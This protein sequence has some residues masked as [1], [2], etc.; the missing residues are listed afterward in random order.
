MFGHDA[1]N[2][3]LADFEPALLQSVLYLDIIELFQHSFFNYKGKKC[4]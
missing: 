1:Q 4:A 3:V 2:V